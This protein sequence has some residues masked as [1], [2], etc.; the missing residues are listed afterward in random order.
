MNKKIIV[1]FLV[2]LLTFSMAF[3]AEANSNPE[4]R[5]DSVEA[6]P[7]E[8]VTVDI[9]MTD[10]PGINTFTLGFDYDTSKLELEDVAVSANLGGQMVYGK[11]VVWFSNKDTTY[12]GKI[13]SLTFKVAENASK[14]DVTV[15]VTYG[16]SDISN[17]DEEDVAFN[18]VP[19]VVTIK[20]KECAH[21]YKTTTTKATTSKN[22]KIETKCTECGDIKSSGTIYYAKTFKLSTTE[23]TYNGKTKTPKVTVK[24]SEG[25]KLV[26][27]EDYTIKV[28]S[29]RKAIGKYTVTVTLKGDYSGT[30]KLYF[31]I[32]PGATSSVS[33]SSQ[34]TSSVKLSWKKVSGAAGYTVYRYSSSKDAYV[35]VGTTT[36]TY[37]TVKNLYAGTSYKFKVVAYGKS[38]GGNKYNSKKY[39]VFTTATKPDTPTLK[40]TAG[41]KQATLRWSKETGTGYQIVY[42]TNS[43]FSSAKKVTVSKSSTVKTTIKKL[44]KGKTYYF[45]VRAYK[46][47]DGKKIYG[48]YSTVKSVKIK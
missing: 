12:S 46:T 26:K 16:K 5:V 9:R 44:T 35:K 17:Y 38:A 48:A 33:A 20:G 43:K 22:G 27:N 13:L 45:K 24:D 3:F 31:Y 30:K 1:I 7:G 2:A 25:N 42:A 28:A 8:T 32:R 21:T 18:V 23:Y 6:S 4:I 10:N 11:K 19:G 34:T 36:K 29:S 37:L 40:V 41:T 14:G 47:V 15:N 39:T